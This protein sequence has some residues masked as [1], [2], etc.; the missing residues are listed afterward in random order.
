MRMVVLDVSNEVRDVFMMS[1]TS[2]FQVAKRDLVDS[3]WNIFPFDASELSPDF[4]PD[5][6]DMVRCD[7]QNLSSFEEN[8]QSVPK[9]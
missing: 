4:N 7:L 6:L 8:V 2:E 1:Y 3:V 5:A 9:C